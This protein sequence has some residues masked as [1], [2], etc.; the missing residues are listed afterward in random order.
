MTLINPFTLT[1][2]N[3]SLT[4][5]GWIASG[6]LKNGVTA[7]EYGEHV[8][9]SGRSGCGW[10]D[11]NFSLMLD[12][13]TFAGASSVT[14][15][16]FSSSASV[17]MGTPD[18]L[19]HGFVQGIGFTDQASP[20]NSHQ[21]TGLR[22]SDTV[23]HILESH[24][25]VIY[26]GI[27]TN[28][29][30]TDSTTVDFI[31]VRE[32]ND[33]WRRIQQMGGG[34]SLGELYNAYFTRDGTF[35]YKPAMLISTPAS[36]G[37]LDSEYIRGRP[38]IIDR[39]GNPKNLVSQVDLHT[40]K[41]KKANVETFN[42]IFP[43]TPSAGSLLSIKRGV[44]ANS[45]ARTDAMAEAI[46]TWKNRAYT[47]SLMVDVGMIFNEGID[48]GQTVTVDYDGALDDGGS[49]MSLDISG[50]YSVY[51]IAINVAGG[52]QAGATL[53]LESQF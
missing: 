31:N 49:G 51:G 15:D 32:S 10:L 20:Q 11:A 6:T 47:L 35:H 39:A 25:D 42:K 37:T 40:V 28:L 46:Y 5:G 26:Q 9:L 44:W 27:I 36:L 16:K 18:N 14:F 29:D 23:E 3:G 8:I 45:Q 21:I 12:G 34:D 33:M 13:Y 17:Q 24:V 19:L 53:T 38:R 4:R 48:I 50:D 41:A 2:L 52:F 22:I 43:A 30:I 7:L 1:S